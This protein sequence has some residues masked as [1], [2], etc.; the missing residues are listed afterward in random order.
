MES[1]IILSVAEKFAH[2]ILDGS[3]T[4][5]IRRRFSI[6]RS[7]SRA[8]I[9]T[10]GALVGE[11]GI[12]KVV[13]GTPTDIW[14]RFAPEIACS[15]AEFERYVD[16][17]EQVYALPLLTPIPYVSRIP[18]VQLGSLV[19]DDFRSPQSYCSARNE[20]W[21]RAMAVAALLHGS[22]RT[23]LPPPPDF[24]RPPDVPGA[25]MSLL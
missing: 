3:K 8:A 10:E 12:G 16:G 7:E 19:D 25:Q 1:S 18:L 9:C 21:S 4:I 22:V 13:V 11:I 6:A 23:E 20:K 15:H 24:S 2:R 5:E 14:N 17:T